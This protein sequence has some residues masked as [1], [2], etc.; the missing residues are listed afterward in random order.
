MQINNPQ[1]DYHNKSF[2]GKPAEKKS[3]DS[4]SFTKESSVR[5]KIGETKKESNIAFGIKEISLDSDEEDTSVQKTN[6]SATT[7]F[8]LPP[9]KEGILENLQKK[10]QQVYLQYQKHEP[11]LAKKSKGSLNQFITSIK[12]IE[13]ITI[14]Q[15]SSENVQ[16]FTDS[17]LKLERYPDGKLYAILKV[18]IGKGM[19]K[20]VKVSVDL[21]SFSSVARA[22]IN[23]EEQQSRGQDIEKIKRDLEH[24]IKI[25]SLLDEPEFVKVL[26][27]CSYTG[28]NSAPKIGIIMEHCNGG[29]LRDFGLTY[30]I[31]PKINE[32]YWKFTETILSG[33]NKMDEKKIHH[34]DMKPENLVITVD[35]FGKMHLKI[36][37]FGLA[38][39]IEEEKANP[40][41]TGTARYM[42]PETLK[43][44]DLI[45][46][47]NELNKLSEKGVT[48]K[49]QEL[50]EQGTAMIA[51]TKGDMWAMGMILLELRTGFV[52]TME[53]MYD[54]EGFGII[55]KASLLN[56]DD[57]K[58]WFSK[59]VNVDGPIKNIEDLNFRMLQVD[60]DKRISAKEAFDAFQKL[61]KTDQNFCV[62]EEFLKEWKATYPDSEEELENENEN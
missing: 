1:F 57:V 40:E 6:S 36:A 27:S 11:Q 25:Q 21:D 47:G 4:P 41:G 46:E 48:K 19:Q 7:V 24:E 12:K 8:K 37:D 45:N 26:A 32:L 16:K 35:E 58:K 61:E 44:F 5:S 29:N 34:R 28:K 52:A 43:G 39:L 30:D 13:T 14:P 10:I 3:E 33:L 53:Q 54:A 50:I 2:P 59:D 31:D 20:T 17:G 38:K 56:Q 23:L 22:T 51:N 42:P 9:K 18:F 55:R 62:S 15:E 60:P 49:G